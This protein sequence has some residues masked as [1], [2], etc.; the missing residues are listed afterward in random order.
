MS[1]AFVNAY[2][3]IE[4]ELRNRRMCVYLSSCVYVCRQVGRY[5]CTL[6]TLRVC[7]IHRIE[8]SI[9]YES[10]DYLVL[11]GGVYIFIYIETFLHTADT[12]THTYI[13]IYVYMYICIHIIT[14]LSNFSLFIQD[15]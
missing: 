4:Y 8:H 6:N 5:V 2:C 11:D 12:H 7:S 14:R 10:M 13:Y 15:V 1:Y 3:N 9:L